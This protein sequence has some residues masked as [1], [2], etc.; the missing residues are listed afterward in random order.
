MSMLHED[1]LVDCIALMWS[2][3]ICFYFSKAALLCSGE[4]PFPKTDCNLMPLFFTFRLTYYKASHIPLAFHFLLQPLFLKDDGSLVDFVALFEGN[5]K[6]KGQLSLSFLQ[7][8]RPLRRATRGLCLTCGV[9][10]ARQPR[11]AFTPREVEQQQNQ[12]VMETPAS[13]LK[14]A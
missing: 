4:N 7:R 13:P 3:D 14:R 1:D 9:L 2:I 5:L 11:R 10:S 6:Q 12:H 8:F